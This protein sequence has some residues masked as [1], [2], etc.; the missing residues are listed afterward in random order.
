MDGEIRVNLHFLDHIKTLSLPEKACQ[1]LHP[2]SNLIGL[3]VAINIGN[4]R[5]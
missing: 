4:G 1:Y 5:T 2:T 3:E